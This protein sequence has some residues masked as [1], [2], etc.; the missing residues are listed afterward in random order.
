LRLLSIGYEHHM[1]SLSYNSSKLSIS[2]LILQL[3]FI[4]LLPLNNVFGL[5]TTSLIYTTMP[6]TTRSQTKT[7]QKSVSYTG[8][9]NTT[10]SSLIPSPAALSDIYATDNNELMLQRST[11]DL[12]CQDLS[13]SSYQPYHHLWCH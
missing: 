1:F 4:L 13:S 3:L 10:I 12:S 5:S 8:L 6:V 11:I 9:S 7:F 2:L